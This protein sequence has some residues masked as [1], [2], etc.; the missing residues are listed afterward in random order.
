MKKDVTKPYIKSIESDIIV[1]QKM[2]GQLKEE[3]K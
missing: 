3:E 2:L 1:L